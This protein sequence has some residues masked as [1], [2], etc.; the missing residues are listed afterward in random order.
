MKATKITEAEISDKRVSSLPTR[1][2]APQTLGGIGYTAKEMKDAF[3]RLPLYIIEK[4]N[5]LIDTLD[6]GSIVG[7]VP[8]G[9]TTL[10]EFLLKLRED[11]DLLLEGGTENEE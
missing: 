1:P 8:F 11:L 4:F 10:G 9:D 5:T 3:D 7:Y 6:D 2:T